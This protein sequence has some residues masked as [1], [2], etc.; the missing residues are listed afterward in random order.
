MFHINNTKQVIDFIREFL[1]ARRIDPRPQSHN[2]G[3][4]MCINFVHN[5]MHKPCRA[6]LPAYPLFFYDQWPLSDFGMNRSEVFAQN[7]DKK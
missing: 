4:K 6:S 7:P 3:V 2:L 5:R 1:E